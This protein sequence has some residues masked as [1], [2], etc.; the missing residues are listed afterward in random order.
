MCMTSHKN[1]V[2]LVSHMRLHTCNYCIVLSILFL[3]GVLTII[4]DC[5][6]YVIYGVDEMVC[7]IELS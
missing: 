1:S 3:T 7:C 2:D 4:E 6:N 5:A